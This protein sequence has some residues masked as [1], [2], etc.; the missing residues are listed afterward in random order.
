[1][2]Y[3]ISKW[4]K[5][6][7]LYWGQSYLFLYKD[8]FIKFHKESI[9]FYARDAKIPALLLADV[10]WQEAGGKPDSLKPQVLLYRQLIDTFKSNNDYSN[11]V[12]VG[13]VAMQ[14]RVVAELLGINPRNL[15][16]RQQLQIS[17]C[18]QT[19]DFNLKMASLHLR[20]LI[21]FDYPDANTEI[22][23]D[24]S[25]ILVGSR[26]NRGIQRKKEDFIR[27]ISL[28]EN[29]PER[30]YISYGL[31]I[32]KRRERVKKLMGIQQ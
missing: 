10:A 22:L 24:E 1:M 13:I 16:N 20:D 32:I 12:S 27:A 18:L 29:S 6:G 8:S 23:S 21:K 17:R 19:D 4:E 3:S 5:N 26:Y 9:I 31:A 11:S 14:I 7:E 25:L 15:S 30:D 2:D 28:P